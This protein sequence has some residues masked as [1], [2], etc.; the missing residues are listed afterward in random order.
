MI[1]KEVT[2][3][4]KHC[5]KYLFYGVMADDDAL[6]VYLILEACADGNFMSRR[7]L[8]HTGRWLQRSIELAPLRLNLDE[9]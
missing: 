6:A 7:A 4:V 1:A 8:D 9:D 3:M 5:L 2:W